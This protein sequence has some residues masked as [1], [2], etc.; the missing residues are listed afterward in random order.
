MRASPRRSVRPALL[1]VV[2]ATSSAVACGGPPSAPVAT[3]LTPGAKETGAGARGAFAVVFAG[4]RGEV[5]D[6]AEPAV[7]MLMN[8]AMRDPESADT[9][10]LPPLRLEASGGV[11]VPGTWRW[12]GTHGLLFEPDKA[13]P[14]ATRFHVTMAAGTR[15]LDGES[16][17][18]DYAF[19][20][21]T[22]RP[23]IIESNPADASKNVRPETAFHLTFNQPMAPASLERCVHLRARPRDGR[24]LAT[25]GVTVAHPKTGKAVQETL[26]VTPTEKLPKDSDI[27]LVVDAGLAGEGPLVGKD[28]QTF[29][30]RTYGPLLLDK[31]TCP[32][33]DSRCEAHRDFTV[34]LSNPVDHD[35]FKAHLK[36]P[37]L[38]LVAPAKVAH[39][40]KKRPPPS[41]GHLLA[42]DP[43]YG[44]RYHVTLTK[45]LRDVFGQKLDR[46]VSFDVDI[47]SPWSSAPRASGAPTTNGSSSPAPAED[48]RRPLEPPSDPSS[49][50]RLR[51]ASGVEI[52]IQ[53]S[54]VEAL[55]KAG[56]KSHRV[57]IGALNYATYGMSAEKVGEDETLAWLERGQGD[58]KDWRWS[59]VSPN[60]PE[61]VRDVRPLDLD[62]LLGGPSSRGTALV[63]VFM[64]GTG[65]VRDKLLTVT[66]LAVSAEV[67]RFGSSVWVTHLS[68]GLPVAG[69]TVALRGVDT[70][71]LVTVTTDPSGLAAVPAGDWVFDHHSRVA[72]ARDLEPYFFVHAGDDWT[73]EKVS[74]AQAS[75]GTGVDLDVKAEADWAG[76]IYADRGVYRPGETMK[77]GGVFRKVDAAGVKILPGQDARVLVEDSQG[78]KVFDGRAK[79]GAFG[80][81]ALD[82]ALSKTSHLGSAT[83]KV[84]LGRRQTQSFTENVLLAAYKASEFK[85]G[86]D[87]EQPSY[88][89]GETAG[90]ALHA[91]FLFGA[92][93]AGSHFRA[94]VLRHASPFAPPGSAGFVTDDDLFAN[95]RTETNPSAAALKDQEGTLDAAGHVDLSV[96]LAFTDMRG[97]EE[98]TLE[99]EV[100]DLSQETVAKRGSVRVHPAA[101]YLGLGE[102][103][104]RFVAVGA[105]VPVKL[106]A[107]DPKGA[108]VAGV[109]TKVELIKRTWTT[110]TVDEAADVPQK[111]SG[112]HDEVLASCDATTTASV[113]SCALHVAAPGYFI[114]RAR[115]VDSRGN[116]VGASASLYCVS[117]R[118]DDVVSWGPPASS[119]KLVL[120]TDKKLY[121]GGDVARI[122]VQNPFK[123]AQAWVTV[124]RGGIL[125]QRIVTLQ[126]PMPTVEIPVKAEYFPNAFV[127][128]RLVRGRVSDAPIEGADIGGPDFRL[129]V[130]QIAVDPVTHRLTPTITT[131]RKEYQPGDEVDADVVVKGHDGKP[132]AAEVTFYAVDEGVLMLTSYATPDPLPA[133][134]AH[135]KLAVF[136]VESRED[137]AR[138][139]PMRNG[140]HVRPLGYAYRYPHG[141]DKGGDGG[142]GGDGPRA[143]FKTTAFFD[144]GKVTN[145]EGRV[146]YH[147]KLPDNLTTFRLMAIVAG[148]DDRYGGGESTVITSKHLMARPVMPRVVRVGDRFEAGVLVSSKDIP[149]STVRVGVSAKGLD[150]AGAAVRDV[151]VPRGGSVEVRFPFV[152]T[153]AGPASFTFTAE[154]T[155]LGGT[156]AKDR[157][158]V[159]RTIDLPV[160]IETV[161]TY[162]ET[163]AAVAIKL[164]DLS[165][166]QPDQGGLDVHLASTAMVG[167]GT[168]FDR[169]IEYPYGCTEQLTSRILPLLVLPDL[170]KAVGAR[171]PARVPDAVDEG[172]GKLLDHQDG[173]GGFTYWGDGGSPEP[174]LSAY[175]MLAVE[176]AAER[177]MFVPK[178][179]RDRG[180]SYL[181]QIVDRA[182]PAEEKS[183]GDREPSPDVEADAGE[184]PGGVPSSVRSPAE[185]RARDYAEIAFVA[186]TLATVGQADP[187]TLN[188][189][190]EART[191]RPLFTQ[192]LL[193]HAMAL[194]HM[195]ASQLDTLA[196]EIVPR[197]R[198][199]ATD[200]YAD[201][202]VSG[203]A[204]FLDSSTRTSALVL[205]ALVA[206]RPDHP[207]ASR[208]AHGLLARRE[209]GA[210][211]STQENVW[212]LLALDA[213]RKAQES[214]TPDFDA[215]VFLGGT[216][217]GEG[218]F[219][220]GSSSDDETFA[221][222]SRVFPESG[223]TL[224]FDFVGHGKLFYSAELRTASAVL[225]TKP[226]DS[227]LYVQKLVR[228]LKPSEL[229][230]AQKTL[231]KHGEVKA[232]AGDLVLVD[233][234]LES[235]E[236]REQVVI[237]DPMPAGLE[238]I[239]FALDTSAQ[240]EV[241]ADDG[242]RIP[243]AGDKKKGASLFDYGLAFRT[244][245]ST[246]REQHDDK[247]LTFLSHI[248]PGIYHFRYLA[249]AT[250]PG[251]F[252]VPP[253]RAACMYSP[254][255]SG[256]SAAS[257][258]VVT[259]QSGTAPAPGVTGAI[260]KS[261]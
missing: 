249:R 41:T 104:S 9:E 173:Q 247:V 171:L 93:M 174:W 160:S 149:A 250:T 195:P 109:T 124:E 199:D 148:A 125:D 203:M 88:V 65:T 207:L 26:V 21:S 189:L 136:S 202:V 17:T 175:A 146:H 107:F 190:F 137:L 251:D 69:A 78:E 4:P 15:S 155:S 167:L 194:A 134:S 39:A 234:L 210:W 238:P 259:P 3:T 94:Q 156:A 95:D 90:F 27:E 122:L 73:Y 47:E 177:G 255:V 66:D 52:G 48:D 19:D 1:A 34:V 161:S 157:V 36:V 54:V 63:G 59:W 2:V 135:R 131:D 220:G 74:R 150:V 56:M 166:L 240:G 239:D 5:S 126:G 260:A 42:A 139:L 197:I 61:N 140:E 242:S 218:H 206:A 72:G 186:D 187:G 11:V 70:R 230:A 169:L 246:H 258:F 24:P 79:L 43:E 254:E 25:I 14:G 68:S 10:H 224:T 51:I 100:T 245:T 163:S 38:K 222:M 117:D 58:G 89:R 147:F 29:H 62:A 151:A 205:R 129:G 82:V 50:H 106:V 53:G 60:R 172:I 159:N 261:P 83:I 103:P 191:G 81:L 145:G 214:A 229:A 92:P 227:G 141:E 209:R 236:P 108:H 55:A 165:K 49:P 30:F 31:V 217:L 181:R 228:A 241:V 233:L 144:A 115:A 188:R 112:V 244:P 232:T 33:V 13:L 102:L 204:D 22:A 118:S 164:G 183:R 16:L 237:D 119:R 130:A 170:A 85:V 84:E 215:R 179:A 37:G 257:R 133:F 44:K 127:S 198:V 114:L 142:G 219:H 20:F 23:A 76:M 110:A 45:G 113:A 128:V 57:P 253:T 208:L 168:S 201:E 132:A 213:Y 6:L 7:T 225:P 154:A 180:V 121:Q 75:Y 123:T 86:V 200:A 111:R 91:E 158:I 8:R 32:T 153:V 12:V 98:V 162:G 77:L 184:E 216:K 252:V 143:D 87:P 28:A 193:L 40:V 256:S 67:S 35:D 120:E 226:S 71:D 243:R 192:A 18:A 185:K 212:A 96:P 248:E 221:A 64:P 176:G 99:G 235:A 101:F 97:P 80:E 178:D 105:D 223:G 231:P 46:D 152:A 116:G 196:G 138:I 182:V 211:R